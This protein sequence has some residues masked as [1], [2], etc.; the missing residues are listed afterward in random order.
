MIFITGDTHGELDI[1]KLNTRRFPEQKKMT[2]DDYVIVCGD[3]GFPWGGWHAQTDAYW[4]KWLDEKPFTTLFVDGNHENFN[5]LNQLPEEDWNGGKIHRVSQ[6]VFHLMRG[7]VFELQNATFFT[8]GGAESTDKAWRTPYVSWWPEERPS[9]AEIDRALTTLD[10]HNW[11]VDY[12][13]THAAPAGLLHGHPYRTPDATSDLLEHIRQH[14]KFRRWYFGHYHTDVAFRS[15]DA[16]WWQWP[17]G[18]Q[19]GIDYNAVYNKV[20][21]LWHLDGRW[22]GDCC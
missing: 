16:K 19:T 17:T 9:Q 4:L 14:L 13:L 6:S 1:S 15:S 11:Q 2:K 20:V 12:V 7:Y 22:C 8:F 3:F 5:L 21:E 18:V 10:A